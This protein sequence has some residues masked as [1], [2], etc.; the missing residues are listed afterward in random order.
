[1][2][3]GEEN[4]ASDTAVMRRALDAIRKATD[5]CVVLIDHTGKTNAEEARGSSAVKAAMDTEVRVDNDGQRPAKITVEVTRDKADEAGKTWEFMLRA[6]PLDEGKPAAVL[7]PIGDD[8]D[9][10]AARELP[11]DVER[12]WLTAE[13]PMPTTVLDYEGPGQ[14][15]VADLAKFMAHDAGVADP[16]GIGVT[17][18]QAA[19]ALSVRRL[20]KT[21]GHSDAAVR[22]AWSA[23]RGMG[24]LAPADGKDGSDGK[25]ENTTGRH[26]WTARGGA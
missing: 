22:R 16:D 21:S 9:L 15:A 2:M 23:L 26:V 18:V 1:M 5:A 24:Y 14:A 17:R 11:S 25:A 19:S 13:L 4:S 3:V 12:R 20:G 8:V 10:P 6:H 7:L